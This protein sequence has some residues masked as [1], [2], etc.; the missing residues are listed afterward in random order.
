MSSTRSAGYRRRARTSSTT[1]TDSADAPRPPLARQPTLSP[2]TLRN[3]QRS[4]EFTALDYPFI[5]L[6]CP[7]PP[8]SPKGPTP[9]PPLH[10]VLAS[11]P[12]SDIS[13]GPSSPNTS[14][15]PSPTLFTP[16]FAYPP[17]LPRPSNASGFP[18]KKVKSAPSLPAS[19]RHPTQ[20]LRRRSSSLRMADSDDDDSRDEED[21]KMIF[22]SHTHYH[23]TNKSTSQRS[24]IFGFANGSPKVRDRLICTT[25]GHIGAGETETEADEPVSVSFSS[26]HRLIGSSFLHS[27]H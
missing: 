6:D 20:F 25:P 23:S 15:E 5:V 24:R 14:S 8:Y 3:L 2:S 7:P 18:R 21:D 16:A 4:F 1:S 9:F 11:S 26:S 12:G 17:V 22:M 27:V 10:P 19:S 13:S